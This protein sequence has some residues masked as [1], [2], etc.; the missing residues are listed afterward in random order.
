[1]VSLKNLFFSEKKPTALASELSSETVPLDTLKHLIPLRKL[2]LEDLEAF[3]LNNQTEVY[4]AGT[5]LFAREQHAD[6]VLYL[7]RGAV[8]LT[9]HAGKVLE[10]DAAHPKAKFPLSGGGKHVTTAVAKTDVSVLRVSNKI[11]ASHNT[12][13]AIVSPLVI[14]ERLH[15]NRLLQIFAQHYLDDGVPIPPMPSV[16]VKLRQAMQ[17]DDIGIADAVQIIQLDPVVAAKLIQVANCPLYVT[18]QPAKSCFDAVNRIGLN[19]TRNLVT[20]FCLRHV[21]KSSHAV[22]HNL[23]DEIWKDSIYLACI[24]FVLASATKKIPPEEA[25]LAGLVFNLGAVP[26]LQFTAELPDDLYTPAEI[27][28]ALPVVRGPVG[29]NV[30]LRWDFPQEFVP[31]PCYAGDWFYHHEGPLDLCDIVILARLHSML[32]KSEHKNLPTVTALPA[33]SKLDHLELSP[34][35]SLALL[36]D[37]KAKIHEAFQAF[38]S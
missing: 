37:A 17:H 24:S 2:P 8:T 36:S 34:E 30:L 20:A 19:A 3:A 9:D 4:P 26:F 27:R 11:M 29:C 25:Q 23:M 1:M 7:M 14:P 16:A 38:M 13:H 12:A 5:V 10:L 28:Q 6:S 21:F 22:I 32:G 18:N 33:T 35:N 15:D 31:I